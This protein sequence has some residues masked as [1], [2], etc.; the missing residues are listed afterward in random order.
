MQFEHLFMTLSAVPR[1]FDLLGL[2]LTTYLP[3]FISQRPLMVDYS[4]VYSL[5]TV[6]P[7]STHHRGNY[8]C[9]ADL[10]FDWFG[11]ALISEADANST[12]AK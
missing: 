3:L 6:V 4:I 2:E 8:H 10:L 1:E 5:Q 11:F 12:S 9:V 7:K